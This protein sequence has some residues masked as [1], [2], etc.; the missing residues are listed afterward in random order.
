[1][2]QILWK[3]YY[4]G[5]LEQFRR[6]LQDARPTKRGNGV[7]RSGDVG[8]R[9]VE[10]GKQPAGE[11]GAG[12]R[13]IDG[14]IAQTPRV[15]V[16]SVDSDGRTILHLAAS[17][18]DEVSAEFALALLDNPS[19]NVYLQDR[20]SGWTALH[21]ALY[22]GNVETAKYIL[23]RDS[24]DVVGRGTPGIIKIKDH[25]GNS[26]FDLY[27]ST[28]A[29][30]LPS[31]SQKDDYYERPV[32]VALNSDSESESDNEEGEG[33]YG[34]EDRD[35]ANKFNGLNL[36]GDEIYT[37]GSN[38][39][40]TL[41][42]GDEDDRQH[43]ER[44][45]L[46]R[47]EHLTRQ[48][49]LEAQRRRHREL[50]SQHQGS[51]LADSMQ[52]SSSL[53][54]RNL[55]PAVIQ[56]KPIHIKDVAMSKLHTAVLTMDPVSNLFVCGFGPG[57]RLGTGDEGSRIRFVNIDGGG[58][59]NKHIV[60]VKL[61]LHH[62]LALTRSG[63]L[64]TWGSNAA[65]Q[66]GHGI[67]KV[68]FEKDDIQLL[69]KQLFGPLKKE[70]VIGI[71]ASAIHSVAHTASGLYTWG[72]NEGQLG[73]VDSD[74]R[75]LQIQ[76]VPRRVAASLFHS[77]ISMV[78]AI[79]R[80][81]I[82]LLENYETWVFA[83]Y[84]YTKLT[85]PL[86]G[87]NTT[88]LRG[89]V[90]G[91]RYNATPN[92]IRKI[93]SGGSTICAL[94]SMGELFTVT[95][96]QKVDVASSDVST[97]NPSKI[98]NALSQPTSVWTIRKEPMAARDVDV[99]QD[100]SVI[101]CTEAGSVW[102][103]EKRAGRK[104]Q[105]GRVEGDRK[106]NTHK[107]SR[108]PR[109]TNVIAVRSN[110]FG[111]FAA[112]RKDLNIMKSDVKIRDGSLGQT[113]ASLS[114]IQEISSRLT[115]AEN[116]NVDT[117][118]RASLARFIN[119][120]T[121][122]QIR[123]LLAL[124]PELSELVQATYIGSNTR[125]CHIT[126]T[127]S[128]L[129]IPVHQFVLKGRSRP[130][131]K[132][133]AEFWQECYFSLEGVLEIDVADDG[134]PRLVFQGM[135]PLTLLA[136]V[137]YIY[138]DRLLDLWHYQRQ[139]PES[140][141]RFRQ[142]RNE[143][144]K[145]SQALGIVEL[146]RAARIMVQPDARAHRDLDIALH[147]SRLFE[148]GD[149]LV[150][151]AD[152]NVR[153]HTALLQKRI[154]FFD[155]LF[156][157]RAAGGWISGRKRDAVDESELV[158]V[159][160]KHVKKNI[161]ELL[162]RHAYSDAGVEVFE[163]VVTSTLDEFLDFIMD[164]LSAANELLMERLCE[165]CQVMLGQYTTM[166]NI[167]PLLNAIG[168]CTVQ[169]YKNT[170]LRYICLNLEAM[171][172]NNLL[173]DLESELLQELDELTQTMQ[174]TSW[175]TLPL[176]SRAWETSLHERHPELKE[177]MDIAAV[178]KITSLKLQLKREARFREPTTNGNRLPPSPDIKA[179]RSP[180]LTGDNRKFSRSFGAGLPGPALGGSSPHMNAVFEMDEDFAGGQ[181]GGLQPR[182]DDRDFDAISTMP[183]PVLATSAP[184]SDVWY[185]SKGKPI[186]N[187]HRKPS[188]SGSPAQ[189][190]AKQQSLAGPANSMI[191]ESSAQSP[192]RQPW[193]EVKAKGAQATDLR[194]LLAQS[195]SS[196][197]LGRLPL[198]FAGPQE[199]VIGSGKLSQKDR[200]KQQQEMKSRS[201]SMP[202]EFIMVQAPQ[203]ENPKSATAWQASTGAVSKISLKEVLN[204]RPT[205]SQTRVSSGNR[206]SSSHASSPLASTP[207]RTHPPSQQSPRP[208]LPKSTSTPAK[209]S[210]KPSTISASNPTPRT[211]PRSISHVPQ[212]RPP[213]QD[214]STSSPQIPTNLP[215]SHIIS[216]QQLEQ[217]YLAQAATPR[218]MKQIQEEQEFEEWWNEESRRTVDEEEGR[219]RL[220]KGRAGRQVRAGRRGRGG[221]GAGG[222]GGGA[223]GVGE[224][225]RGAGAGIGGERGR[226]RRKRGVSTTTAAVAS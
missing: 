136:F 147:D 219:R 122:P 172:E 152:G 159:D 62:T 154:P 36:D 94:S 187:G 148:D 213:S 123:R 209:P 20:E 145:I 143:I 89:N 162:L 53:P 99:S 225:E 146:E 132:A 117:L 79:E 113:L 165:I 188:V 16:N 76:D 133:L 17:S 164:V 60:D 58:L 126:S 70:I 189:N 23:E 13:V 211:N 67:P 56:N 153:V 104:S 31:K 32:D 142:V 155:A 52:L 156:A 193:S 34:R 178:D 49:N 194:T 72:K 169:T 198:N 130:L 30:H 212:P 98:R 71:T 21:R 176:L 50:S 140:A 24:L 64:Y 135:D 19:V 57:G 128:D 18:L 26:P 22:Y 157:G 61:G 11:G 78:S 40:L 205:T 182:Q 200:K 95:V 47:P 73:L 85:F 149:A 5:N 45:T 190:I 59:R 80:A 223:G 54:I 33:E 168:P 87:P 2:S 29:I 1:M 173:E 180:T 204:E 119:G 7:G 46:T 151:L 48:L 15:D 203:K 134:A 96:N 35:D 116:P 103:R 216:Q 171:L 202:N 179:G 195:P 160:L 101:M 69:P 158:H 28:V 208:Q 55:V 65:G 25:E 191:P 109:L 27:N 81:T 10:K 8:R 84:G 82:C 141:F 199:I 86:D 167:S 183:P 107:F 41:G 118:T 93:S 163:N 206:P 196:P 102:R 166:R 218:S 74:A 177:L 38:K 139:F 220:E 105:K 192:L 197:P 217:D 68:D 6:I 108:V 150:E 9:A 44:V 127:G 114:P 83:N 221:A 42:F 201:V 14:I 215:M 175:S 3:A 184:K 110:A 222:V 121:V 112:V 37:F 120:M 77:S 129:T 170:G 90:M 124:E 137:N 43:P 75:S 131:R 185:D 138:T 174:A 214:P 161:F 97:T 144:I 12:T 91:T 125:N 111:A 92:H 39:N 100:E 63:D 66:L 226:G 186:Q 4:E 207:L 181:N 51:E 115:Q 88:F 210:P 224:V 106:T